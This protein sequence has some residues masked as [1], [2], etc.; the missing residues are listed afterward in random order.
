[1]KKKVLLTIKF[2]HNIDLIT[3]SSSELF[4]LRG[5]SKSIVEEMVKEVYP[6]YLSEYEEIKS[7]EE[8]TGSEMST[9]LEY[10]QDVYDKRRKGDYSIFGIDPKLLFEGWSESLSE[11]DLSWRFEFNLTPYGISEV[12]KKVGNVFFLFS[13]H[14]NPN[15]EMQERLMDIAERYHLG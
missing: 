6:D 14:D 10:T 15:W 5:D 2:D 12:K 11:E 13:I 8:M 1:M 9:Y 4:V 3:N 7:L